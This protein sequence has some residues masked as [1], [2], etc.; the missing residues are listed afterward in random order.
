MMVPPFQELQSLIVSLGLD[1]EC[2]YRTRPGRMAAFRI[3]LTTR[4]GF[5]FRTIPLPVRLMKLTFIHRLNRFG[6]LSCAVVVCHSMFCVETVKAAS[7]PTP[8]CVPPLQAI[9]NDN[10]D[11]F[12]DADALFKSRRYKMAARA[13]YQTFLCDKDPLSR[14]VYPSVYEANL[15]TPFGNAIELAIKGNFTLASSQCNALK[16]ILPAFT[17]AGYLSG[18]FAWSSGNRSEARKRWHETLIGPHFALSDEDADP[19]QVASRRMLQWS[20]NVAK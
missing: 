13:Y 9:A 18:I 19:G 15:I 4:R 5:Y 11:P 1:R 2:R 12:P 16:S 8:G 6:L 20:R 14:G 3:G 7:L 10:A 17:E